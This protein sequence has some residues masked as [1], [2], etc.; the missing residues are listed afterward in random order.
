MIAMAIVIHTLQQTLHSSILVH[1]ESLK[2]S[3][4]AGFEQGVWTKTHGKL[5]VENKCE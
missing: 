1:L 2:F 4:Q 3:V 5:L